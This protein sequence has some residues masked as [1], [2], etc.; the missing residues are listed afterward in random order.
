MTSALLELIGWAGSALLVISLIQKAMLR[1]RVLNL[2]AS[3]ILVAYNALLC[4]W[5]MVAMN[6]AVVVI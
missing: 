2:T 3:V 5:P 6:G 1:L 4:V